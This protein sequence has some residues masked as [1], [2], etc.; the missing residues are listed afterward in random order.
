[1]GWPMVYRYPPLF[2]CLFRPL[3]LLPLSTT[4]AL[5]A[6]LKV[7]ALGLVIRGWYRR[8]AASHLIYAFL[9]SALLLVPYLVQ[10]LR[11]G[12]LQLLVVE[13]V[14][15][16]LLLGDDRPLLGSML[17]GLAAA[18]KLWPLF[19]LPYLALRARWRFAA[20]ALLAAGVLTVA[21][22]LW[23][24]WNR[25]FHLLAEWFS[26]ERRLNASGGDLWYPSQSL[27]GVMVRY[28]T[29]INYS[30]FPD[31]H[32]PLI[33]FASMASTR[34]EELWVLLAVALFLFSLLW[35]YRC[36]DEATAYSI[37]FCFLLILEPNVHR[38]VYVTLLW[39]ALQ[40]GRVVNNRAAPP[41]VRRI[42]LA[43]VAFA[44]LIPLVPG[45]ASQR[46]AQVMGVDFFAVLIP[47]TV[48]LLIYSKSV[49]KGGGVVKERSQAA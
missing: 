19:F 37:A 18:I 8:F 28:L 16:A 31:R 48:G 24:G 2:L 7:V 25:T 38:L 29:L 21:P 39:P 44:V 10:D 20:Q 34:V 36:A 27:H 11:L 32:Y 35:S 12:N 14:C 41:L 1:M 4:T 17:L 26:Q 40:A 33:N 46:L 3:A 47:L 15:A 22:S 49:Y 6:A 9:I 42:L 43:A 30:P 13:L 45:S 23:L 5:W